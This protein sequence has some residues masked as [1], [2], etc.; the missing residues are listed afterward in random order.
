MYK[1]IKKIIL[2]KI[3]KIEKWFEKLKIN[4]KNNKFLKSN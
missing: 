4:K 2:K 1:I 3:K